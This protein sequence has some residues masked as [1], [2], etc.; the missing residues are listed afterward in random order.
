MNIYIYI[1]I[2]IYIIIHIYIYIY[3][4]IYIHIH[5]YIYINMYIY[6]TYIYTYIYIHIY[7]YT[8]IYIYIHM[9]MYIYIYMCIYICVY[10]YI[11]V[12]VC[13]RERIIIMFGRP[14]QIPSSTGS[15]QSHAPR[16]AH[17]PE[18]GPLVNRFQ[19]LVLAGFPHGQVLEQPRLCRWCNH[20]SIPGLKISKDLYDIINML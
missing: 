20:P 4:H 13:V 7:M 15:W 16:L 3:I 14:F 5:V 18:P 11:Y 6:D 12:C 2:Y 1:Y 17:P 10:I 19:P 9:C 8:C